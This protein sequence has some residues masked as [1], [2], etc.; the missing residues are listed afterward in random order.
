[1]VRVPKGCFRMGDIQ[2]GG[3]DNEQ[4]VHRVCLD[5]YAIGVH[6]V[7]FADF[8][9]FAA[10]TGR[11]KPEDRGWGRGERPVIDVTGRDANAYADW[12]SGQTG[13]EYRLPTEAEWEYTARAGRDTRYWWGNEIGRNRA[14]CD[15]CG[16]RWDGNQTAPVGFFDPNPF[17]LYDTAG[18]VWEWTCSD[19]SERYNGKEQ[20]CVSRDAARLPVLRGGSWGDGPSGVRS[21]ARGRGLP[22]FWDGTLGLRL[23]RLSS[24][25]AWLG[26]E[27]GPRS[28]VPALTVAGSVAA[29]IHERTSPPRRD[30][31]AE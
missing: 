10:A 8:D 26:P 20:A 1:M 17:G 13:E 15:G 2:D 16:S 27:T 11:A 30:G 4:P 18:N 6:E 29:G 19:Y 28:G 9:R 5:G 22:G 7:A 21:A 23:V 25:P 24:L 31:S 3:D 12:L 14:N